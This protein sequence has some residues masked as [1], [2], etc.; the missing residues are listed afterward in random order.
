MA[1]TLITTSWDDGHVLDLKL[2]KLLKKYAIAGTF[3][4]SPRDTEI[5]SENRLTDAQIKTLSNDFEIG[6]HTMTHPRLTELEDE[7]ARQEI[8]DSKEYLENI[9]GKP[10]NSFCY[11]A[12]YYDSRHARMVQKAGFVL[13]RTVKRFA[14][15]LGGDPLKLAT[16]IHAYRHWSDALRILKAVGPRRFLKC[17]FNWDELAITVF[18]SVQ[19]KGGMFHLWGHSWEIER[20]GDWE[21]LERVLKRI[22]NQKDAAYLTNSALLQQEGSAQ[23]IA[24]FVTPYFLPHGGGLERYAFEIAS[25]LQKDYGWKVE[26]ITSGERGNL[27]TTDDYQGIRVHRLGYQFKISNTPFSFR[28][29]GKVRAIVNELHPTLVN[30]HMPVPG[31]GDI[32]VRVAG[33]HPVVLTYHAGTMLKK[34]L[35]ADIGI[36]LYE[37]CIL[38]KT[39][40][41]SDRIIC[42]SEFVKKTIPLG[43]SGMVATV[44]TPGVDM[45][46]FKRNAAIERNKTEIAFICNFA[47]MHRLK[48][49]HVLVE[50]VNALA[51]KFPDISLKVIGEVG[52]SASERVRFIGPKTGEVL[53]K[54]IQSSALLV[55]SSLAPAESFGMVLIE[56]MA[57]GLPVIGSDAGGIPEVIDNGKDGFIVKSG[58]SRELAAAIERLLRDEQ[59]AD[60]MGEA[61]HRKVA[62][63]FSWQQ[64]SQETANVFSLI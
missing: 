33:D 1:K 59:L 43:R 26:V 48:G 12:G 27:D 31:I 21:R 56:A 2:A 54:E 64:K 22:S 24:L 7:A 17:Y 4:I 14:D 46:L 40:S 52:A 28:W 39:I 16:T 62:E 34:K 51:Q 11:P 50:A 63:K 23:K 37:R 13:G 35:F 5:P 49:L 8:V 47:S 61:G 41:K 44:V 32:A 25:R 6:A 19:R 20:N 18:D 57:C 15:M 55:L 60:R 9:L 38:P 30:V 58:D 45:T 29:F 53:V 10:V 36:W 3:Y 42:A